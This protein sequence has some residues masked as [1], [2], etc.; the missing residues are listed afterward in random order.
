MFLV[1]NN[2]VY[3]SIQWQQVS[4]ILPS[5]GHH[6]IKFKRLVMCSVHYFQ[7]V[8]DPIYIIVKNLLTTLSFIACDILRISEENCN[9]MKI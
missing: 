7:V 5:S 6:C 4:V 1:E 8:W 2:N 9:K 3:Y